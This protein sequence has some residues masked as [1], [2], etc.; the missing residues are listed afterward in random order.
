MN[1]CIMWPFHQGLHCLSIFFLN[2]DQ[3]N[4]CFECSKQTF[5]FDFK[6]TYFLLNMYVHI[7][8]C[9]LIRSDTVSLIH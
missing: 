2:H 7:G 1:W 6:H 4:M 3:F 5:S 9:V 8:E